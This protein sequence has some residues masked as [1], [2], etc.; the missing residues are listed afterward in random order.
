[1]GR[2]SRQKIIIRIKGQD[3]SPVQENKGG[4][5]L[6]GRPFFLPALN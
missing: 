2:A 6:S 5:A 1:V 4:A 3:W